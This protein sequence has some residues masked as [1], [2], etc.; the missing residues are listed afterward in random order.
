MDDRLGENWNWKVNLDGK[1]KEKRK[2]RGNKKGGCSTAPLKQWNMVP[3]LGT[4]LI[5]DLERPNWI[6]TSKGNLFGC[7]TL[8][9]LKVLHYSNTCNVTLVQLSRKPRPTTPR[10]LDLGLIPL[11][12]EFE[13]Y[14]GIYALKKSKG[15]T[16]S[17][18]RIN[19]NSLGK[20]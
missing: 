9:S 14:F 12:T 11:V 16:L 10:G 4:V 20:H 2:P 6:L 19:N 15:N 3:V 17:V 1:M 5:E 18:I 7:A 13:Q 8:T